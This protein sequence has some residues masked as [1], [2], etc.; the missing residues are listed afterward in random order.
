MNVGMTG[1]EGMTVK[2]GKM[3]RDEGMNEEGM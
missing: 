1:K 2:E 3:I